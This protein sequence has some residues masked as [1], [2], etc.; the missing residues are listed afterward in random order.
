LSEREE[1]WETTTLHSIICQKASLDYTIKDIEKIIAAEVKDKNV[2]TA[3]DEN[4][5]TYTTKKN[6]TLTRAADKKKVVRESKS[7]L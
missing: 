4:S 6:L 3:Y 2:L 1:V 5:S 7:L